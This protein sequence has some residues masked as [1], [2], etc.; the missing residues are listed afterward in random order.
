MDRSWTQRRVSKVIRPFY[1]T[2]LLKGISGVNFWTNFCSNSL[3]LS[4]GWKL[5]LSLC[6]GTVQHFFFWQIG[7]WSWGRPAVS[8][9]HTLKTHQTYNTTTWTSCDLIHHVTKIRMENYETLWHDTNNFW[10]YFGCSI[11]LHFGEQLKIKRN[12]SAMEMTLGI[13]AISKMLNYPENEL[14]FSDLLLFLF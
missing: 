8:R 7:R 1:L 10:W 4:S 5:R 6:E 3:V 13:M 9:S 12:L 14:V 11:K 2:F